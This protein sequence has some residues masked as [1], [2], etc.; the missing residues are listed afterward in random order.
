MSAHE[1]ADRFLIALSAIAV[2]AVAARACWTD[3]MPLQVWLVGFGGLASLGAEGL[4]FDRRRGPRPSP[5]P[6]TA[7]EGTER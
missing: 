7:T 3:D 5:A 6:P 4:R 1:R 2:S